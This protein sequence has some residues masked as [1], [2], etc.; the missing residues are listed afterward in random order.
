MP[1][2]VA[3]NLPAQ[4]LREVRVCDATAAFMGMGTRCGRHDNDD[5]DNEEQFPEEDGKDADKGGRGS[6]GGIQW[7][8][9]WGWETQEGQV[10]TV[11]LLHSFIV[12]CNRIPS[13]SIQLTKLVFPCKNVQ[14]PMRML[15]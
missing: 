8:R 13:T 9:R 11:A 15:K 4:D 2:G 1:T 3:A 5:D 14:I 7:Q 10:L 6:K 12:T